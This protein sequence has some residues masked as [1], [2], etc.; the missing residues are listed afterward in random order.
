M[1]TSSKRSKRHNPH[2]CDNIVRQTINKL[3]KLTFDIKLNSRAPQI[4]ALANIVININKILFCCLK[5]GHQDEVFVLE[6]HPT[7]PHILLSAGEVLF[8]YKSLTM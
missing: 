7:D 8:I 4:S 1:K 6:A 3:E 2:P 5:Q